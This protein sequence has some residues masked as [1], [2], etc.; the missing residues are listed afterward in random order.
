MMNPDY[1][2][3]LVDIREHPKIPS[4][5]ESSFTTAGHLLEIPVSW[6][7]VMGIRN[8]VELLFYPLL[9]FCLKSIYRLF[10]LVGEY[11]FVVHRWTV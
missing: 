2:T 4:N 7:P 6:V 1:P 10:A 8:T 3:F 9:I 11:E 5:A